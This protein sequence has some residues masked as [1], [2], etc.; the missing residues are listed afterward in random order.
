MHLWLMH[1][2]QPARPLEELTAS[3]D[4]DERQRSARF[5]FD[6]HRGRFETARGLLRHVLGQY[7]G[8]AASAV[9]FRYGNAGKPALAGPVGRPTVAFNL[10]HSGPYALLGLTSGEDI[11]VDIEVTR[12]IPDHEDIARSSFATEECDELFRLPPARRPDAFL[13]CW[14]RKEAYVKALGDGLLAPLDQFVVS[15]DPRSAPMLRSIG[16]SEAAAAAWTLWAA[17]PAADAWAA[18]AVRGKPSRVCTF[19]LA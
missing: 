7:T 19:S 5:R 11:G 13:A 8:L 15:V 4:A 6:V 10:S 1:L 18:L 14:T 16:G 3:L 9:A 2:D 12:D 17:Q